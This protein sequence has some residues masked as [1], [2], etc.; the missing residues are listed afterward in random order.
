M[1][2]NE[3]RKKYLSFFESNKH[4]VL[5]S[6]PLLP[7]NDPTTLFTGSGMQP[8]VPYLLGEK[9]PAGE[10]ITN[11]QRCFRTQDIDEVGDNRHT[12][13]F[14]ML[15]NWSLGEYFK[16]EQIP[17]VFDFVVNQLGLDPSRIYITCFRGD[18]DVEKDKE[19]AV[20]WQKMFK[21]KGIDANIADYIPEKEG[22]K[23]GDRIFYYD[24][25]KNW[26]S[27]GGI[28]KNMPVGEPG[29]PDTEIFW[30]F[31]EDLGLHGRSQWRKDK[32]HVNCDCG[33]FSEIGNSVFMEY[34]K[35]E[36]GFT[37]L[38]QKNVDF[39]GGLERMSSAV[40]DNPDIFMI[41]AF[42]SMR[43]NLE[44][45]SDKKYSEDEEDTYA[46]RVILDHIRAA[47]FL[48]L[49]GANPSNKDQGYFTRR[50][51]RRAIRYAQKINI[52]EPFC[53]KIASNVIETYQETY[54]DLLDKQ[55][56]ILKEMNKE[57]GK[58]QETI[59]QGIKEF[60]K[61]SKDKKISGKDA[62]D[63]YQSYG[64]PIELTVELAS[65]KGI[66]VDMKEFNSEREKHQDVSR[67][68][69]EKKFKG[70]LADHD[71]MSIKYHTATH[72]LHAAVREVLGPHA[73]QKGSNITPERLR[74]DFSHPEKLTDDEKKKIE[75]LVNGAIQRD[76]SVTFE[77][78]SV[79]E[80][81]SKGAIG[82][83]ADNYG[84]QVKVYSVGDSNSL[85]S[86]GVESKTFSREFCGGPH[87]EKIGNLGKFKIKKEKSASAGVRRIRAVL[88]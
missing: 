81:K 44:K 73:V 84:D 82:L 67:K 3:I 47:T 14:E 58:F 41:D 17:W 45:L 21:E 18:K 43:E 57:E 75:D 85:P 53:G 59:K 32:C 78:M 16:K 13:F 7:E 19:S 8:I 55:D 10:R 5:P 46:F 49:D 28:K 29:G 22:M 70:G 12:T 2:I 37:N 68:G 40:M 86:A 36:K 34:Q 25:T 56:T 31:G 48:I 62:F 63:L 1:T 35:T 77:M 20:L 80:A 51:I 87:V 9:H 50:L 30:D 79:E 39:G 38:K 42:N 23:D 64:F 74:F 65:E 76:Y 26:W 11:S 66:V 52:T 54:K 88:E 24:E 15:G 83:F 27:R 33:R 60:A 69:I 4:T 61:L 71:E 6:A 72:L